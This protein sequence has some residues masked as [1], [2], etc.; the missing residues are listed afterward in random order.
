MNGVNIGSAG[1][2]IEGFII[3]G[4]DGGAGD[5]LALGVAEG[6]AEGGFFLGFDAGL[7]RLEGDVD[8]LAHGWQEDLADGGVDLA[9]EDGDGLDKHVGHVA[10]IERDG[11]FEAFSV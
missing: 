11:Y 2:G 4:D 3:D 5:G 8:E 9:I 7:G 1:D 10:E 6:D